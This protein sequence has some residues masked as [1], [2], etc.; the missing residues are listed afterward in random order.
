M[1]IKTLLAALALILSPALTLAD[2]CGWEKSAQQCG[3]GQ[4]FDPATGTCV[5]KATS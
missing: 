3:E 5:D 4:T 2:G 1:T